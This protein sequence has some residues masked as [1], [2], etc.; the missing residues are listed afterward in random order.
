MPTTP[1]TTFPPPRAHGCEQRTDAAVATAIERAATI[2]A[3]T[4]SS[5]GPPM[6]AKLYLR[7]TVRRRIGPGMEL[8]AG[9]YMPWTAG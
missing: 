6:A 8:G 3:A 9:C 5:R 4:L 7:P 1:R 2:Q